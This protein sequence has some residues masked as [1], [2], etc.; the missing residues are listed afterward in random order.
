M[1]AQLLRDQHRDDLSE[2]D[3]DLRLTAAGMA[4]LTSEERAMGQMALR[5]HLMAA[6]LGA[7]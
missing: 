2:D 4:A 7:I 6:A 5:L 1:A 3:M